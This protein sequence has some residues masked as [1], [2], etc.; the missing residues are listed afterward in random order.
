V[1]PDALPDE[2]VGERVL[3]RQPRLEDAQGHG[4][5][6]EAVQLLT[7]FAFG[8]LQASRIAI[9]VDPD[10]F[11][12]RHVAERL[13]FQVEGIAR[14]AGIGANGEPVD[15]VMHAVTRDDLPNLDWLRDL[16]A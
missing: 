15:L 5:V 14:K 6:R 13:G 9:R 1:E 4:Y 11:R 8:P 7:R 12:S 16:P 3:V 2:L 10:N